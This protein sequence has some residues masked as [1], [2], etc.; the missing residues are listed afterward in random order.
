MLSNNQT[1]ATPI[2]DLVLVEVNPAWS[3]EVVTITGSAVQRLEVLAL[4]AGK[5]QQIDFAG[6]GAAAVAVALAYEAV[7]ASEADAKGVVLARG[8][9]VDVASIVWPAGAT[10]VQ[11]AAA[12]AQLEARGLVAR[13]AL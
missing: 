2:T 4:V 5:Y 3:R 9:V 13:A 8:A 6:E 10:D 7:D 1:L 11:K 12:L